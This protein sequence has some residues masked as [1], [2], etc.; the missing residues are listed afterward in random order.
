MILMVVF[1]FCVFVFAFCDFA[2]R[3]VGLFVC[4][5]VFFMSFVVVVLVD[6]GGAQHQNFYALV[7]ILAYNVAPGLFY[8]FLYI[9]IQI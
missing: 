1:A 3:V 6:G 8:S 4:L 9:L 2:Y 7:R 5:L